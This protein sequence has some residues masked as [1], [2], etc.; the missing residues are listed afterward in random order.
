VLVLACMPETVAEEVHGAALPRRPEDLGDRR[1][2][3]GV[4][5]GDRQLHAGQAALDQAAQEGRPER[6]GL[7]GADVDTD[8]LPP[9]G[10]VHAVGDDQRLAPDAATVADLL[11]LG[12]QPQIDIVALQRALAERLD[13]LIEQRADPADLA[14]GDPQPKRLDELVDAPRRDA[15]HIGL[16]HDCH[17][18][19]LRTPARLQ[20]R[21]KVA[22]LPQLGDLQL[23]L[24]GPRVPPPRAIAVSPRRAILAALTEPGS[25]QLGD[26]AL[27]QLLTEP[28]QRL[29]DHVRVPILQDAANDLLKRHPLHTG[30]QWCLLLVEP[31]NVRR[32]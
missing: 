5:V 23:N 4:G 9:A 11:D 2:Q 14:L 3:P 17:Q 7:R 16:L 10:L 31:W 29:A 24:P 22:A 20:E 30:H 25:D 12:V 18:R 8:D 27:H 26:L 19:L 1:L 15:A 13:L 28:H 6:L 21:R 32:S